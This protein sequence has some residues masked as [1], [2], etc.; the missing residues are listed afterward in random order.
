M[1][2]DPSVQGPVWPS[3]GLRGEGRWPSLWAGT[4]Q[5]DR[6]GWMGGAGEGGLNTVG[7]CQ[8]VR[9]CTLPSRC[10]FLLCPR[11]FDLTKPFHF[12]I[13]SS[14]RLLFVLCAF[15]S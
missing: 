14:C 4:Q 9:G 8:T 3:A 1:M 6:V 5:V 10:S 13:S 7:C 12:H 15:L 2:T 11:P